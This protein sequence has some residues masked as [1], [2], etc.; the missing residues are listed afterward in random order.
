MTWT[1]L[2]DT[3]AERE[4]LLEVSRSARLLLVEA[5]VWCNRHLL[6]GRITDAAL[7]RCTDAPDV[8]ELRD[9]LAAAGVLTRTEDGRAWLMDWSDQERAAD[10]TARREARAETQA[11]YR[12]RTAK[13]KAGD[14]TMCDPRYCDRA[15]TGNATGHETGHQRVTRHPPDPT[16]PDPTCPVPKGQGQGQRQ[17]DGPASAGATP[18]AATEEASARLGIPPHPHTG[19]CCNALPAHPIH[20]SAP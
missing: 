5:M 20:R 8:D 6:D 11:R 1:K 14:H 15:V 13:H 4:D 9:E 7:R 16:R 19:D 10:V 12:A 3:F 17:G 2:P 18:A